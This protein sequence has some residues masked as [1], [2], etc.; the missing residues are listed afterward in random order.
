MLFF[1]VISYHKR[2]Q[3]KVNTYRFIKVNW[4]QTWGSV[5][6]NDIH[7][8]GRGKI[9]K[10]FKCQLICCNAGSQC[11]WISRGMTVSVDFERVI[12]HAEEFWMSSCWWMSLLRMPARIALMWPEHWLVS[13]WSAVLKQGTVFRF[14]VDGKRQ[15]KRHCQYCRR[16]EEYCPRWHQDS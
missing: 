8:V 14:F 2:Q 10:C 7:D 12:I 4:I 15:S 16:S 5:G 3:F 1:L 6:L 11:N 9:I 13:P